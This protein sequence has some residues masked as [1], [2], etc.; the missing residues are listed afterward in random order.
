MSFL[1]IYPFDPFF[2]FIYALDHPSQS[3]FRPWKFVDVV[4]DMCLLENQLPFF[5]LGKLFELSCEANPTNCTIMELTR[6][7]LREI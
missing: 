6:E 3:F 4:F 7:L 2:L 5:F 1:T